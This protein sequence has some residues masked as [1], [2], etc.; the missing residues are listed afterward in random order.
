V[1]TVVCRIWEFGLNGGRTVSSSGVVGAEVTDG[2]SLSSNTELLTRHVPIPDADWVLQRTLRSSPNW[3][4]KHCFRSLTPPPLPRRPFATTFS[5]LC[6][7]RQDLFGKA[8]TRKQINPVQL[9]AVRFTLLLVRVEHKLGPNFGIKFFGREQSKGYS[10]LLERCA[11][12]V[13]LLGA[14]GHV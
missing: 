2:W 13:C 1:Q 7:G 14:L 5:Q 12:L 11:L 6:S 3:E 10:R 4:Q 9:D 8:N